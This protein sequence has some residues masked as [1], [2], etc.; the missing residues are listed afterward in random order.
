MINSVGMKEIIKPL[1]DKIIPLKNG[2]KHVIEGLVTDNG[3]KTIETYINL[4]KKNIQSQEILFADGTKALY[5]V[6]KDGELTFRRWKHSDKA[7]VKLIQNN[8]GDIIEFKANGYS[9]DCSGKIREKT[10]WNMSQ[11]ESLHR[12]NVEISR[13]NCVLSGLMKDFFNLKN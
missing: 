6:K 9:W 4:G 13:V 11:N 5:S 7:D 1:S 10:Y 8:N 2:T 3:A 12:K